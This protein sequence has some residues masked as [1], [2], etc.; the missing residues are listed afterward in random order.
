MQID[1]FLYTIFFLFAACEFPVE[2]L[3]SFLL[4]QEERLWLA[5]QSL[6]ASTVRENVLQEN[7]K[8]FQT[9]GTSKPC[10]YSL[11]SPDQLVVLPLFYFGR[12]VMGVKLKRN[13]VCSCVDIC[14]LS[15]LSWHSGLDIP[16]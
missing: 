8:P 12:R 13:I 9:T 2:I 10:S 15:G 16:N 5:Q 14:M 3:E 1:F 11:P 4:K 6:C 7:A